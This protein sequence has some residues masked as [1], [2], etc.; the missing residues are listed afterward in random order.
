MK[1]T[2]STE[3]DR[4]DSGSMGPGRTVEYRT[5]L[6]ETLAYIDYTADR[7]EAWVTV[8]NPYKAGERR[9]TK[10]PAA[11]AEAIAH[12]HIEKY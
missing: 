10:R 8:F 7:T 1:N 12:R 11:A 5:E 2:T 3:F 9:Y 6:G 4:I